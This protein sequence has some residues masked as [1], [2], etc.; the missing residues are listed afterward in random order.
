MP[1]IAVDNVLRSASMKK[2]GV[3]ADS[4]VTNYGIWRY[5]NV[6]PE[7]HTPPVCF[8]IVSLV[9][10]IYL[11]Y[12]CLSHHLLASNPPCDSLSECAMEQ[13]QVAVGYCD[14]AL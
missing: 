11:T 12:I 5:L 4:F 7:E 3:D 8:P 2:K 9:G 10:L 14:D 1:T 6:K 13:V